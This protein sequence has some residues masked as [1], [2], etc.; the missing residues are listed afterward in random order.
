MRLELINQW[1]ELFPGNK[2][3]KDI[4]ES[5]NK[6][7]RV[8]YQ[9]EK[10]AYSGND[11]ELWM[12]DRE[13]FAS[14]IIARKHWSVLEHENLSFTVCTDRGVTHELVRHDLVFSQ[15]STR[16]CKYGDVI[17]FVIPVWYTDVIPAGVYTEKQISSLCHSIDDEGAIIWLNATQDSARYY[18]LQ[19]GLLGHT[20]QMARAVLNNSLASE[21]R[22]SG[23]IRNLIH[24]LGARTAKDVHPQFRV[25]AMNLQTKLQN[26]YPVFF[27]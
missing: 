23:S 22:V 3:Y 5:I 10:K 20:P 26:H 18:E 7:G 4:L 19:L 11:I 14:K 25:L 9:S 12:K 15:E 21:V 6:A 16:Y 8:C 24:F 1:V 27:K 2:S 13:N 17:K